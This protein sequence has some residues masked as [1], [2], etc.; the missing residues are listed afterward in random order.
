MTDIDT[1]NL[2]LSRN[3]LKGTECLTPATGHA[4]YSTTLNTSPNLL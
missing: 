2:R 4:S 3:N 1:I